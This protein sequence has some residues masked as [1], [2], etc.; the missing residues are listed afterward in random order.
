[1]G[2][3]RKPEARTVQAAS[4]NGKQTAQQIPAPATGTPMLDKAIHCIQAGQLENALNL[5]RGAGGAPECRNVLSVCL[6]RLGRYE[7][8]IA[9]LRDLV[10][11]PG[12]TWMRPD[13]PISYKL[14]FATALLLGGRPSGAVEILGGI[15][16]EKHAGV[17]RLRAAISNWSNTLTFW[18]RLNWR[19]G[20][21]APANCVVLLNFAPGEFGI[22]VLDHPVD[23]DRPT[24]P[25]FR[26]A[27]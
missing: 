18:Q 9:V 24:S 25:D 20:Q 10:L 4:Q 11:A 8:A 15:H 21:I 13:V 7:Q 1:M 2:K 6:M 23:P 5:L 14:N 17:V 12:C 19:F 16:D 27:A 22:A 26:P 3:H